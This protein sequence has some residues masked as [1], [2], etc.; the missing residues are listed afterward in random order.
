MKRV[1]SKNLISILILIFSYS[2]ISQTLDSILE[3]PQVVE[4][5]KLPAR[6]TFFPYESNDLAL[7]GQMEA[8]SR[9][10]SLNGQW[11]FKWSKTPEKRPKNFYKNET[12]SLPFWTF[13]RGELSRQSQSVYCCFYWR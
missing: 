8:S 1:I 4:I 6:A 7:N 11:F 9:F 10:I 3:N 13:I 12:S 5:N 2:G